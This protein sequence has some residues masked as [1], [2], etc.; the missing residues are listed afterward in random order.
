MKE[1]WKD[2][3]DYEGLYMISNLGR[4][5]SNHGKGRILKPRQSKSPGI[6]GMYQRVML[7]KDGV[8]HNKRIHRL[9]AE[10]FIPN[11][12]N[13]P[14]VDHI[15]TNPS[16]NTVTNL[17]WCTNQENVMNDTTRKRHEKHIKYWYKDRSARQVAIENG[18]PTNVYEYR[19]K[20]GWDIER[21]V[22]T[23]VM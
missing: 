17:R 4:V 15:D 2:I 7:F 18:I 22:T 23:P 13:K 11:P 21:V 9:V 5:K 20:L 6:E 3:K 12:D 10:A 16:N 8:K 19:I 1:L 14:Y